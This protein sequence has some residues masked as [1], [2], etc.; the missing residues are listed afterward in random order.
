MCPEFEV[1]INRM[2]QFYE[3]KIMNSPIRAIKDLKESELAAIRRA[4]PNPNKEEFYQSDLYYEILHEVKN[5]EDLGKLETLIHKDYS[6]LIEERY[7][8]HYAKNIRFNELASLSS[9]TRDLFKIHF[10]KIVIESEDYK[11]DREQIL[12]LFKK[13]RNGSEQQKLIKACL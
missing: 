12:E 13:H 7:W 3:L 1:E 8:I 4:I 5:T 2:I 6:Y 11:K 9:A 10:R